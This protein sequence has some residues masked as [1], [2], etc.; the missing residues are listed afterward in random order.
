[1]SYLLIS[2]RL[3]EASP[4]VLMSTD[5]EELSAAWQHR[6]LE[7][8]TVVDAVFSQVVVLVQAGV[9]VGSPVFRRL[10]GHILTTLDENVARSRALL[11]RE[12]VLSARL[13]ERARKPVVRRERLRQQL[14]S[15]AFKRAPSTDHGQQHS[16]SLESSLKFGLSLLGWPAAADHEDEENRKLSERCTY[17]RSTYGTRFFVSLLR[18]LLNLGLGIERL[19]ENTD[20]LSFYLADVPVE[21]TEL[22][23]SPPSTSS[24]ERSPMLSI[25]PRRFNDGHTAA[26]L[27]ERSPV[28]ARNVCN[29]AVRSCKTRSE[30]TEHPAIL[31]ANRLT[32]EPM[33]PLQWIDI[34]ASG[35]SWKQLIEQEMV[36][37][38]H[39]PRN[40]SIFLECLLG[41]I[42]RGGE[43]QETSDAHASETEASKQCA[44]LSRTLTGVTSLQILFAES[45]RMEC[46][47]KMRSGFF[48]ALPSLLLRA[49]ERNTVSPVVVDYELE[50]QAVPLVAHH[51][52]EEAPSNGAEQLDGYEKRQSYQVAAHSLSKQLDDELSGLSALLAGVLDLCL[53][54]TDTLATQHLRL[55]GKKGLRTS[56]FDESAALLMERG[57]SFE[58]VAERFQDDVSAAKD[59]PE[60][61]PVVLVPRSAFAVLIL[62]PGSA[63]LKLH[64]CDR[65]LDTF[66]AVGTAKMTADSWRFKEPSIE[67][68]IWHSMRIRPR[69]H[70]GPIRNSDFGMTATIIADAGSS[71]QAETSHTDTLCVGIVPDSPISSAPKLLE[72]YLLSMIGLLNG[73]LGS[74]LSE[75]EANSASPNIRNAFLE[76]SSSLA[77]FLEGLIFNP[78]YASWR[79]HI[80][81]LLESLEREL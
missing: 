41:L 14:I 72:E 22:G 30:N 73:Y 58:S 74:V 24:P 46:S 16:V 49:L 9:P 64:I 53:A 5:L 19:S 45:V 42:A 23:W 81:D 3:L 52:E 28:K 10:I 32:K 21:P 27:A 20:A 18:A 43:H 17:E 2:A 78:I 40:A 35:S 77:A 11:W 69:D 48:Q 60:S 55:S 76:T 44:S 39:I 57:H 34:C 38:E 13:R 54:F 75:R 8:F 31:G 25:S 62:Y 47:R 61:A 26:Q 37:V 68:L 4:H 29:G 80:T 33:D 7:E 36:V 1:L 12:A 79:W 67:K 71:T 15:E 56:F 59:F 6:L 70:E 51:G 50:P 65:I 63:S 66:F